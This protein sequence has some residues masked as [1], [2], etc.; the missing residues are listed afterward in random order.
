MAAPP[1]LARQPVAPGADA[2]HALARLHLRLLRSCLLSSPC[3]ALLCLFL[4]CSLHRLGG[5]MGCERSNEIAGNHR[6]CHRHG[7]ACV[8]ASRPE[9]PL[10]RWQPALLLRWLLRCRLA[11]RPASLVLDWVGLVVRSLK[12]R[13]LFLRLRLL[14]PPPS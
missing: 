8:D 10:S 5:E 12:R 14:L 4:G 7:P 11:P 1:H 9:P 13:L 2:A 3:S 6:P